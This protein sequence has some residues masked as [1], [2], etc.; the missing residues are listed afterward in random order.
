M[1]NKRFWTKALVNIVIWAVALSDNHC[2]KKKKE[3]I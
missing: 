1:G 3:I 2:E